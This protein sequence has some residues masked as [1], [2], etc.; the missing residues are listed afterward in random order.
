MSPPITCSTSSPGFALPS[1]VAIEPIEV[2]SSP[3]SGTSDTV[4]ESPLAEVTFTFTSS[5]SLS[6]TGRSVSWIFT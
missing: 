2:F 4:S 3:G 6:S 5:P 1:A